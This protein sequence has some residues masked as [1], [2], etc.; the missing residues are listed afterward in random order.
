MLPLEERYMPSAGT[1]RQV[2]ALEMGEN[3][4]S[5]NGGTFRDVGSAQSSLARFQGDATGD[6]DDDDEVDADAINSDLDD[7]DEMGEENNEEE[8]DQVM[9][10]TYDKVARVKNKWKCTLKDGILRVDG[11]EYVFHKGQGEFEW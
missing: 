5:N 10:C 7:P 4:A 6:D 11:N 9:L 1:R 8:T 2:N 3:S